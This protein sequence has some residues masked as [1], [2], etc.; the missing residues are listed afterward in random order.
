MSLVKLFPALRRSQSSRCLSNYHRL[1]ESLNLRGLEKGKLKYEFTVRESQANLHGVLHGAYVAFVVDE[2]STK[3]LEMS[4][5]T[6]KRGVSVNMSVSYL[7]PA[8]IDQIITVE[9]E[10]RKIGSKLAYLEATLR[11]NDGT[12]VAHGKHTKFVG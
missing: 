3:V 6:K 5:A 1:A 9:A 12:L 4:H 11:T 10:C 8:Y 7:H 2:T